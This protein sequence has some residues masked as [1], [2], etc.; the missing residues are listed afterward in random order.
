MKISCADA[1]T[2][3]TGR[4]CVSVDRLY[5]LYNE[6][7]SD[8]LFT[9]QLVRAGRTCEP[10][11]REQ[12]PKLAEFLD[13]R[14]INPDTYKDVLRKARC[15]FGDSFDIEPFANWEQKNPIAELGEMLD[16]VRGGDA[17]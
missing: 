7:T 16:S 4:L 13:C 3:I 2:V 6:L 5:A 10:Y 11:V 8:T 12:L 1:I 9:H 14:D 17:A 15:V